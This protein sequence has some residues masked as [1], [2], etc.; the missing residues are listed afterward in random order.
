MRTPL[1]C[2]TTLNSLTYHAT[3]S[4]N[5]ITRVA[6]LT[7]NAALA[8][9]T[10]YSVLLKGGIG[11]VTDVAGNPLDASYSWGFTTEAAPPLILTDTTVTDFNT[12]TLNSCVADGT[13]GD[14]AV[15]LPAAIDEGFL[16]IWLADWLGIL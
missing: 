9:S 4:Y 11:G 1:S 12:G 10:E 7:P 14:G 15:R 5:A 8:P 3:V 6:T 16:W 13:I 2:A